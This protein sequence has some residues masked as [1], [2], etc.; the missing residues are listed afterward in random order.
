MKICAALL[1]AVSALAQMLP[2]EEVWRIDFDEPV[3]C[4]GTVWSEEGTVNVMVGLDDRVVRIRDGEIV[5]ASEPREGR[6][7]DVIAADFGLG[8]GCEPVVLLHV[9]RDRDN[10]RDDILRYG[11]WEVEA[12]SVR[13]IARFYIDRFGAGGGGGIAERIFA[14]ARIDPDQ[15]ESLVVLVS[16]YRLDLLQGGE[17]TEQLSGFAGRYGLRSAQW[18]NAV[19]IGSPRGVAIG[20]DAVSVRRMMVVAGSESY[21]S[22]SG[23]VP[24]DRRELRLAAIDNWV[25]AHRLR[26][27]EANGPEQMPFAALAATGTY[28][29][30]G[31][32][33][34]P[35]EG[36]LEIFAADSLRRL[37]ARLMP[38]AQADFVI[39]MTNNDGDRRERLLLAVSRDGLAAPYSLEANRF[40]AMVYQHER[41]IVGLTIDDYDGDGESEIITLTEQS[42]IFA[43]LGVLAAPKAA[44]PS[45]PPTQPTLTYFPN[46]FNDALSIV[47][48]L[49]GAGLWSLRLSDLKGTEVACIKGGWLPAGDGR[50]M[51]NVGGLPA[52]NYILTLTG[53]D[54][55][56]A[57]MVTIVK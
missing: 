7:I 42:L 6:V 32:I 33:F 43:R 18:I 19:A 12:T 15:T 29:E 31:I 25:G 35:R 37:N 50:G 48:H 5:W 27:D 2:V 9:R 21:H 57:G 8:E 22:T 16:T 52:G 46:P 14:P 44:Q 54:A 3:A 20:D 13:T 24:E 41:D 55:L 36:V 28:A 45:L 4:L 39:P 34:G 51:L 56:A 1:I 38:V 23:G 40:T 17:F 10:A 26:R 30:P 11:N 49:P 53:P 47:Y